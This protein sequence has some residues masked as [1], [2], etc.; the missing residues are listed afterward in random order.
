MQPSFRE[1][2]ASLINISPKSIN[3]LVEY[4]RKG[5]EIAGFED[6]EI[7]VGENVITI[8]YQDLTITIEINTLADKYSYWTLDFKGE[9]FS[10]FVSNSLV[11]YEDDEIEI[12]YKPKHIEEDWY[13]C[14]LLDILVQDLVDLIK[15]YDR[16]GWQAILNYT[17]AFIN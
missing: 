6:V 16:N 8:N 4:I 17:I 14:T 1:Y 3:E 5:F 2:I 11:I 9:G 15:A 10:A 7:D 13:T 12:R